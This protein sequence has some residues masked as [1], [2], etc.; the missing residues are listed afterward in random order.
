MKQNSNII[1]FIPKNEKEDQWSEIITI[2]K[3]IGKSFTAEKVSNALKNSIVSDLKNATVWL[4]T[5]SGG[6]SYHHTSLGV[7]YELQDK[8]EILMAEYYAG[9]Y[10]CI[11]VQFT[12]RPDSKLSQEEAVKKIE[13]FFSKNVQVINSGQLG[14]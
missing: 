7:N 3:Y 11:G 6:S 8:K 12:I 9:P 1:E 13:D 4:D 5:V 14:A 2:V 10:D